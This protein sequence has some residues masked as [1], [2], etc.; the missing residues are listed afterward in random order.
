MDLKTLQ[1]LGIATS[2]GVEKTAV[3]WD[4]GEQDGQP[5]SGF[6]IF[7]KREQ[8]AADWEFITI[9]G[10]AKTQGDGDHNIMARRVHRL[11]RLGD[12]GPEVIPFDVAL[13]WKPEFLLSLCTAINRVQKAAEEAPKAIGRAH[14]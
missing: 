10:L 3:E 2:I 12:D 1:G 4:C 8:S 6:D 11:V 9:Q 14:V 13:A 5:V 7:V